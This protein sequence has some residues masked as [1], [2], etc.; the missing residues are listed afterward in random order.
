VNRRMLVC[1]KRALQSDE[2]DETA[3]KYK[4]AIAG[5][6]ILSECGMVLWHFVLARLTRSMRRNLT[7]PTLYCSQI[8]D[9]P[10][11]NTCAVKR[12]SAACKLQYNQSRR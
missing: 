12:L 2:K 1:S 6:Q 7:A 8:A 11:F 10:S 3:T 9:H 5:I 4:S